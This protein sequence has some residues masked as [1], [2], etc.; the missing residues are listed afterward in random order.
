VKTAFII[1]AMLRQAQHDNSMNPR[2][3]EFFSNL[4]GRSKSSAKN[5]RRK[6]SYFEIQCILF[7]AMSYDFFD[8]FIKI[9][10][11]KDRLC[12]EK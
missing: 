2:V 8:S 6:N 3:W 11:L 1:K 5:R 7:L 9:E 4:L 12:S 10:L